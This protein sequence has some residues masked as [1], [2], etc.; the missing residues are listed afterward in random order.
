MAAITLYKPFKKIEQKKLNTIYDGKSIVRYFHTIN[1]NI[2]KMHI[3]VKYETCRWYKH[4]W[5][6]SG[7]SHPHPIISATVLWSGYSMLPVLLPANIL[8]GNR[9]L[10]KYL[11]S[12]HPHTG[13]GRSS[14]LLVSGWSSPGCCRYLGRH[15]TLEHFPLSPTLSLSLCH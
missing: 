14:W 3:M 10:F 4:L 8:A 15:S 13:P 1:Y 11:S 12:S 9:E 5:W 7:L 2:P 6:D